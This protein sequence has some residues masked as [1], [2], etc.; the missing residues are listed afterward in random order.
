MKK[1][2]IKL[3]IAEYQQKVVKTV[4]Q[5]RIYTMGSSLAQLSQRIP[6]VR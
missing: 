5:Q 6:E 1:D 4:F 3:L 2:F